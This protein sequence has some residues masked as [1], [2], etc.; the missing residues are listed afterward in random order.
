M[1]QSNSVY[2]KLK[3]GG[4]AH[5]LNVLSKYLGGD[6]DDNHLVIEQGKL[7]TIVSYYQL[8]EDFDLIVSQANYP[9][10]IIIEREPDE[11]LDY[12]HF[13]MI[14]QGLVKQNIEDKDQYTQADS[15]TGVFI[16]N[17]LF[18]LTSTFSARSNIQS[19]A[20]KFSKAALSKIMPEAIELLDALFE[21]NEPKAYHTGLSG[22]LSKILQ[23][24]FYYENSG[25]G[26]IP[27][28]M[29]KGLELLPALLQT[30]KKQLDKDELN[31]LHID[32][33]NRLLEIKKYLLANLN[34]KINIEDIA[35]QFGIS[36]S[37]LKRDFKSLFDT[38]I[39]KYYTH[40][41]MDEAHRRLRTGKYSV[42]EVAYDLG[43]QNSSK[44]SLMFK[45]VKGINPKDVLNLG[46]PK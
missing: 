46:T 39:Y 45:Q 16:Y 20:F 21:N 9:N 43:Y 11:L 38:T 42:T 35:E 8:Y 4:A 41:K 14:N 34:S 13:N 2:I 36:L 12:Y 27:L 18:P 31:G 44:F 15:T 32:D 28:V 40:A 37:K 1:E 30:L 10:D 25:Y 29:S 3:E 17:G 7:K 24:L 22:E 5:Y 33:Y 6:K 26:R 19:M 23:E